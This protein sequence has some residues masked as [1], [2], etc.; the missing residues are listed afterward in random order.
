MRPSGGVPA[1]AGAAAGGA[2]LPT[3]RRGAE[4][5]RSGHAIRERM[6]HVKHSRRRAMA[7]S[8]GGGRMLGA[9]RM[10]A[11]RGGD[12]CGLGGRRGR[13]VTGTSGAGRV[14]AAWAGG[15]RGPAASRQPGA[16][17]P[18]RVAEGPPRRPA[19]KKEAP[20]SRWVG[21][22]RRAAGAVKT[23]PGRSGRRKGWAAEIPTINVPASPAG[24]LPGC[25]QRGSRGRGGTRPGRAEITGRAASPASD[26]G[27][28][29]SSRPAG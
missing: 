23:D 3:T 6:F 16:G 21:A 26:A 15:R 13:S 19:C 7:S 11:A 24:G 12:R 20:P 27:A 29:T 18:T 2:P 5:G 17:T 1:R 25:G 14:G 10:E 22:G 4:H 9:G 8:G 28:G